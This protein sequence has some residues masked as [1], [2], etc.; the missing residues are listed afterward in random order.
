MKLITYRFGETMRGGAVIAGRRLD[1]G[2]VVAGTLPGDSEARDPA[3]AGLDLVGL[4]RA[5]RVRL[6]RRRR[7]RRR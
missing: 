1:L 2:P 3:G 7:M 4:R 5:G 6:S